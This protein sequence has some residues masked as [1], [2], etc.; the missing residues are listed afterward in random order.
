MSL[1]PRK[2]IPEKDVQ[3]FGERLRQLRKGKGWTQL[4][5]ARNAGIE[6]SMVCNY[7]I[8]VNYP[9][10][11]TLGKLARALEVSVDRLLGLEES[12]DQEIQDR[13]LYQLFLEVD[14]VDFATQGLIK[15][16]VES[17]LMTSRQVQA[18]TGTKG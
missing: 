1:M 9:P 16:V 13:R 6:R 7:E 3:E 11:P 2:P 12:T 14:R 4:Q 5:L 18:R 10:I 17:L 15:Q 8:G